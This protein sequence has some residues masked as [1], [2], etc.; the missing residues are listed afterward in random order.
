LRKKA[1]QPAAKPVIIES[2]ALLI[3]DAPAVEMAD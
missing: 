1:P 3:E 2:D